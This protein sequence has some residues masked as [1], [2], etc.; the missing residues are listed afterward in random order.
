[1]SVQRNEARLSSYQRS[2][3]AFF[4][5]YFFRK[6]TMT[7][8]LKT[9]AML[10]ATLRRA[11]S[12]AVVVSGALTATGCAAATGPAFQAVA[13]APAGKGQVYLYSKSFFGGGSYEVTLDKQPVGVLSSA[14]FMVFT[15]T[16]GS[17]AFTVM[18][19]PIGKN[20]EQTVNIVENQTQ[21]FEMELPPL[22][23]RN[24]LNLGYNITTRSADE[25]KVDL[26]DLKA[27]K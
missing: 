7:T 12:V 23:L 21:F 2:L 25:A 13:D 17:H 10:F 22:L 8:I 11:L 3:L 4:D 16:P 24:A 15:L 19:R 20:Y 1:M 26:K 18:P 27:V 9:N 14:S 5:S 6:K